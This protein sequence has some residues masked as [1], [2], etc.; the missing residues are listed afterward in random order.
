MPHPGG[1]VV[2]QEGGN[3]TGIQTEL[4]IRNIIGL[5]DLAGIIHN[6]IQIVI[7]DTKLKNV[8]NWCKNTCFLFSVLAWLVLKV[9]INFF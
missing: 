3:D 5:P 8:L 1:G 2:L 4:L 9:Y 6:S 7:K